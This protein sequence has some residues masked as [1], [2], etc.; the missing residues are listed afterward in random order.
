MAKDHPGKGGVLL[1]IPAKQ[2]EGQHAKS[3]ATA[4]AP[5]AA[6]V[7]RLST[8]GRTLLATAAARQ[9]G[10]CAR[11]DGLAAA[12]AAKLSVAKTRR[13]MA[14]GRI[15]KVAAAM[16]AKTAA[17]NL[18]SQAVLAAHHMTKMDLVATQK[19]KATA[20]GVKRAVLAA[21]LVSAGAAAASKGAAAQ[22]RH[23]AHL[24][25]RAK[26]GAVATKAAA[27]QSRRDAADVQKLTKGM[28]R[29]ALRHHAE[30]TRATM[31]RERVLLAKKRMVAPHPKRAVAEAELVD[32]SES[33][34][35]LVEPSSDC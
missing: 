4:T 9:A 21:A 11:R 26:K 14:L 17:K 28:V 33:E 30:T 2:E 27:V 22:S 29:A 13:A 31:L 3:T 12:A 24:A 8:V 1:V 32:S 5:P 19:R 20:A 34:A 25:A 10:A 7:R 18:R 23:N 6:L 16:S 35:E 15:A